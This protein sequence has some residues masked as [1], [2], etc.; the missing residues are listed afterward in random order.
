MSAF[1]PEIDDEASIKFIIKDKAQREIIIN[2]QASYKKAENLSF[3]G[4]ISSS[5]PLIKP[6]SNSYGITI[7]SPSL[8]VPS[9][10]TDVELVYN[11]K[12]GTTIENIGKREWSP[13]GNTTY[14]ISYNDVNT[15]LVKLLKTYLNFS[16]DEAVN[17]VYNVILEV[18]AQDGFSIITL[19]T[20][21]VADF[22]ETPVL[23]GEL[24]LK[25]GNSTLDNNSNL[26]MRMFNQGESVRLSF[27]D[28]TKED[29]NKDITT[30][31]IFLGTTD[32]STNISNF[33]YSRLASVNST[34]N[35]FDYTINYLN[36][37]QNY[38][39]KIRA[40]DSKGNY[41]NEIISQTYIIGCRTTTP[42]FTISNISTAN[43]ENGTLV[44][45]NFT[46]NDLGGS[47]SGTWDPTFYQTYQNF[48]RAQYDKDKSL[49]LKVDIG[50]NGQ[51]LNHSGN[52]SVD[53]T[54][55]YLE[56]NPT[57]ILVSG[58]SKTDIMYACF[59]LTIS[60]GQE[61]KKV[62][63]VSQ[64]YIIGNI[65]TVSYRQNQLGINTKEIPSDAILTIDAVTGKDK[66]FIRSLANDKKIEI[67]LDTGKVKGL[68][69][70]DPTISEGI[71][72]FPSLNNVYINE[73][74]I[75]GV[76]IKDS[77]FEG[78]SLALKDETIENLKLTSPT[79]NGGTIEGVTIKDSTIEDLASAL[80]GETIENLKLTSP[81]MSGGEIR[82]TED[83]YALVECALIN[84]ATIQNATLLPSTT[85]DNVNINCGSW[86]D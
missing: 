64:I 48:N 42:R 19:S 46:L 81:M 41:S 44:R 63:A 59:T 39:F 18:Q 34:S 11:F 32:S 84:M 57:S 5:L 49:T 75:K 16:S 23:S 50:T 69:L 9:G 65:P 28:I 38:K 1:L 8:E 30:Y 79:V 78:L 6:Y 15:K 85:F 14:N 73:G 4:N 40:I 22:I 51:N 55:N 54:S 2:T 43:E 27:G 72:S 77:T 45:F 17:D 10:S 61:N 83:N 35:Y 47:S 71:F 82:G 56:F 62:Q 53:S 13:N 37:N 52:Y 24:Q 74:T 66:I 20:F 31:E 86:D 80:E 70:S 21:I 58:I 29:S 68:Q 76:T 36:R 25:R 7:T 3:S 67:N 12:I 26:S 33:I 60:Y